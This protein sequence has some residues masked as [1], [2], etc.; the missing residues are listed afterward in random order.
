[1][2]T[3]SHRPESITSTWKFTFHLEVNPAEDLTLPSGAMQPVGYLIQQ[4]SVRL[5]RPV[6]AYDRWI[7]QIP[8][9][10]RDDSLALAGSPSY[11]NLA[12]RTLRRL[13]GKAVEWKVIAVAPAVR[14]MK[15]VGRGLTT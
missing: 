2:T 9:T 13:L 4:H 12:L 1:M 11:V 15:E 7:A 14:L 5:D 10:Y 3:V 8:S 6:Q